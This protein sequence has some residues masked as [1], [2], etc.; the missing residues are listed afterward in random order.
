MKKLVSNRS[1]MLLLFLGFFDF[2][3]GL[4]DNYREL[5]L[6]AN[7]ISNRKSIGIYICDLVFN[8]DIR[9]LALPSLL[10]FTII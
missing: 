6:S 4:F 1:L 7:S 2:S 10:N 9:Y 5:W 3:V 8:Y